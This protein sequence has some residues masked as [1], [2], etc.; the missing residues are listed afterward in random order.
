MAR[1]VDSRT[2]SFVANAALVSLSVCLLAGLW[3]KRRQTRTVTYL[4]CNKENYAEYLLKKDFKRDKLLVVL[5]VVTFVMSYCFS[6][7]QY[8]TVMHNVCQKNLWVA[9]LVYCT[10]PK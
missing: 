6:L 2:F 5:I 10:W 3:S 8:D 9:R 7:I 4:S 1:F